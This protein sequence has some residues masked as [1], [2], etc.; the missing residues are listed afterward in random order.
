MFTYR[1]GGTVAVSRVLVSRAVVD[2]NRG[3]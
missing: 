2:K 1:T 3:F